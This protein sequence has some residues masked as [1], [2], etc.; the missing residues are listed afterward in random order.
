MSKANSVDTKSDPFDGLISDFELAKRMG[1]SRRFLREYR[2][3]GKIPAGT[4][5]AMGCGSAPHSLTH[6]RRPLR[7][8]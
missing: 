3:D 5:A 6:C 8:G 4:T 1:I 2:R 7:L